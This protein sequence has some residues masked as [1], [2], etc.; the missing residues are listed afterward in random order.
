MREVTAALRGNVAIETL[1]VPESLLALCQDQLQ[2]VAERRGEVFVLPAALLERISYGARADQP[3]AMAV[4][5]TCHLDRLQLSSHPLVAILEGVE[6]PGNLGAVVRSADGAGVE[7]VIV[8][9]ANTDL[10]NPNAIRASLG[11][12]FTKQVC[13]ASTAEVVHWLQRNAIE[14]CVTRVDA[15][16]VYD[17]YDFT[18]PTAIVLG[19]EAWGVSEAWK[20]L[21]QQAVRL[22]MHGQ[23]DSLNVSATAAILFYEADRQRRAASG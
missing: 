13:A 2:E 8:A 12:I 15:T 3:V 11:T 5:P 16:R 17:H 21:R 10:Y 7:A 20:A 19:S 22:P 23:A 1:F 6:K 9:D 4:P 14:P 18:A